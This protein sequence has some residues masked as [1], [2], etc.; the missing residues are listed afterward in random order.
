MKTAIFLICLIILI[1]LAIKLIQL[2]RNSRD[3]SVSP[4]KSRQRYVGRPIMTN[5]E[6]RAQAI[7]AELLPDCRIYPQV[8]MAAIIAP[9]PSNDFI[10]RQ[11]IRGTFSQKYIDFVI[12]DKR[13]GTLI[14]LVELDDHTHNSAKDAA[15]DAITA[16]AGYQTIRLPDNKRATIADSLERDLPNHMLP[17][18]EPAL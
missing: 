4:Q 16:E 12:E 17:L 9:E 7:L 14:A 8:A 18:T 11:R 15:R 13:T 2:S 6:R 10:E 5:A 3:T 1:V